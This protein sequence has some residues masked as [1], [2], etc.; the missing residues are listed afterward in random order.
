MTEEK[1]AE[2]IA[3]MN[4]E[5]DELTPYFEAVQDRGDWKNPIDGFIR[6]ED[7]QKTASAIMFFTATT[8]SFENTTS[9]GWVRVTSE[10]YRRGPAGDH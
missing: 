8:A 9:P 5:K 3:K 2:M 7:I 6:E 4:A 1:R 10:G